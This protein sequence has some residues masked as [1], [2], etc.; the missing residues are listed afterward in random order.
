MKMKKIKIVAIALVC[1][2]VVSAFAASK[3]KEISNPIVI[4]NSKGA[5]YGMKNPKWVNSYLKHEN[6]RKMN[7]ALGL[8]G[9]KIWVVTQSGENLQFLE[10]WVNNVDGPALVASAI[11]RTVVDYVKSSLVGNEKNL[12]KEIEQYTVSLT[13]LTLAGLEKED[14]W[15]IQTRQLKPG[16]KKSD[17]EDDYITQYQYM[18]VYSMDEDLFKKQVNF[19]MKDIEDTQVNK[20]GLIESLIETATV[21]TG[22]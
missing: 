3:P 5:S 9:K 22:K 16:L 21:E 11:E 13:A 19:A 8:K 4:I 14:E 18:V 6:Q 7:Q 2:T 1:F 20:D 10:M 15:W 12:Q 17:D